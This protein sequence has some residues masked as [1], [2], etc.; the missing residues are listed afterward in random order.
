MT[1][2]STLHDARVASA[3]DRMFTQAE[4]DDATRRRVL[5]AWPDGFTSATPQEQA[6]AKAKVYMPIS[7][8][9]GHLLYNL[10]RA[11]RPATVVEFGR[12]RS[13]AGGTRAAGGL[14]YRAA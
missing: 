10:I 5:A 1:P 9:G 3:L 8:Q 2:T 14:P 13:G 4:Q 7:A 6:D 12:S 11:A